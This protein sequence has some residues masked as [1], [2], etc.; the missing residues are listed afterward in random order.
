M[1][2]TSQGYYEKKI[3]MCRDAD[4]KLIR[5][6][7]RA[8]TVRELEKKVFDLRQEL[9]VTERHPDNDATFSA[10]AALWLTT[11]ATKAL[12]TLQMYKLCLDKHIGPEI[13]DMYFSEITLADIQNI[14]NK[15]Y[16]HPNTCSKIR[17]TLKQVFEMAAED[18]LPANVNFK[19]LAM[20]EQRKVVEKRALTDEEKA[21]IFKADF[22][23]QERA[24]V[25]ILYYTGMRREEAL[26]LDADSFD[27]DA[28]TVTVSKVVVYDHNKTVVDA[29][30]AK[31]KYSLRTIPLPAPCVEF[32][33]G[34]VAKCSGYLFRNGRYKL[35]FCKTSYQDFFSRIRKKLIPYATTAEKLTAHI[36]RHNYATMLYYSNIS[37][38]QAAALMGQS[39]TAMIMQV[40]AHLDEKK[41]MTVEKLDKVFG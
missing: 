25:Y 3:T 19:R 24:Y 36:F 30:R 2:K 37:L 10:Y 34:Y 13:G 20:P 38:K 27:F 16:A 14:I 15:N 6:S 21:A 4:G 33:R 22:T 9:A 41:E 1:K 39:S 17:L 23:E 11:K 35:P 26:A 40:Y 32:L 7:I 8:K 28:R 12:N 18:G 5:K 29:D 31:N